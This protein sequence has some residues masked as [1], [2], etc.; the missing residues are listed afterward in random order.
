MS[1]D[2]ANRGWS[3]MEILLDEH[4]PVRRKRPLAPLFW[5]AGMIV[6]GLLTYAIFQVLSPDEKAQPV[7]SNPD[8]E[9]AISPEKNSASGKN[10]T[11]TVHEKTETSNY[12]S[13]AISSQNNISNSENN[14]I[15]NRQTSATSNK[16]QKNN[17]GTSTSRQPL[18]IVDPA[19]VDQRAT[20]SFDHL[21]RSD[22]SSTSSPSINSTTSDDKG[23]ER[24]T[25]AGPL[26]PDA[27]TA[28]HI[29]PLKTIAFTPDT[30]LPGLSEMALREKSKRYHKIEL[31]G[32]GSY[33]SDLYSVS[34][35]ANM[36]HHSG[37]KLSLSSGL[38]I[39][40]DR[41]NAYEAT[42]S[43]ALPTAMIFESSLTYSNYLGMHNIPSASFIHSTLSVYTP[44]LFHFNHRKISVFGGIKPGIQLQQK[45]NYAPV[46][47]Q[48]DDRNP[49]I[50][51]GSLTAKDFFH[52]KS[53]GVMQV[54]GGINYFI[55][56]KLTLGI[57]YSSMLSNINRGVQY[58][59]ADQLETIQ[60][61]E[62]HRSFYSIPSTEL[63]PQFFG[64]RAGY[65]FS[66]K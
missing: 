64:I 5:F 66:I 11:S 41:Y 15:T 55:N 35:G 25:V 18:K 63:K 62:I 26:R 39:G 29:A 58:A 33:T 22:A 24:P 53:I 23:Y 42:S 43:V 36:Y 34:I 30:E 40:Y 9:V 56:P 59:S 48:D 57:V 37:K 45:L 31:Y 17:H 50:D 21:R 52:Q 28:L 8:T 10:E 14:S 13:Q 49:D 1:Q 12:R 20:P 27:T 38:E 44:I 3:Q 32:Q 19:I 16:R 65:R 2:L 4:L 6:A 60:A 61:S 54:T 47:V 7:T 46:R 51:Q